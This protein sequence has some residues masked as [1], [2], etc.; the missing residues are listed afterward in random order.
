MI[1]LWFSFGS[2]FFPVYDFDT[3]LRRL[4][5]NRNSIKFDL[6]IVSKPYPLEIGVCQYCGHHKPRPQASSSSSSNAVP[7]YYNSTVLDDDDEDEDE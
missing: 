7:R 1:I 5:T 3:V 6:E 4:E 2:G